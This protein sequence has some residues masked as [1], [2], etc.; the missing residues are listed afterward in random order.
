MNQ[1]KQA[2]KPFPKREDLPFNHQADQDG[3]TD[4]G[5]DGQITY[6]PS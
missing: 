6:N 5:R 2:K 1:P 3:R 4:Y